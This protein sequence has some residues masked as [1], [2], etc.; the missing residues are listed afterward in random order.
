M[1]ELKW[2]RLSVKAEALDAVRSGDFDT[3]IRKYKEYLSFKPN[4][5]DDDAWAGLGG[6]YRRKQDLESSLSSYEKAYQ[7]N[8]QSTYALGNIVSLLAA[9]NSSA[10]REKLRQY[11]PNAVRLAEW[12]TSIPEADHWVWYDLATTHLVEGLFDESKSEK[13]VNTFY[14]AAE[15]T[16][17]AAEENF[18]SVLSNLTFLAEHN[19]GI[20]KIKEVIERISQRAEQARIIGSANS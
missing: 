20:P 14:F 3:A 19:P 13:A 5:K 12:K 18:R 2:V 9:R 17:K 15:L 6:A 7:I 1:A 11:L 8:S 10:D 16:P 4:E